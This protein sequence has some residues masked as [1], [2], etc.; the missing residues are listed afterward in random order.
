MDTW[1]KLSRKITDWEW[2][3]DGNTLRVFVHL[4]LIAN[5]QPKKWKGE[6]IGVGEAI[7]GRKTLAD[8]LNLSEQQVRTALD[9]LEKSQSISKRTTNKYTV[10]KV[11]KYCVYQGLENNEQ[12]TNNQQITNNQPTNNQ[13]ITTPKEDKTYR[14]IEEKNDSSCCN[15]ARANISNA[16]KLYEENIGVLSPVAVDELKDI[17]QTHTSELLELAIVEA[18][19]ANARNIKYIRGV[20]RNWDNAGVK[21]VADAQLAIA[22]HNRA[23][24]ARHTLASTKTTGKK[25][26]FQNY[27]SGGY[28]KELNNTLKELGITTGGNDE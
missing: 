14:L 11:L 16:I 8:A 3:T 12:P 9:K 24:A 20:L 23:V 17:L 2:Y 4:L 28:D 27:G 5:W 25:N 19:K 13:Q 26:T 10:I 21:T 18:V 7:V 22:E 15:G 6:T 1:V